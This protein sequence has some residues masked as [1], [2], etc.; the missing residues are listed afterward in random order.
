MKIKTTLAA[1]LI[2]AT[3]ALP[4]APL[5]DTEVDAGV[6]VFDNAATAT[7][8]VADAVDAGTQE[9]TDAVQSSVQD[10]VNQVINS[11]ATATT[12]VVAEVAE[13]ATTVETPVEVELTN[14]E[15]EDTTEVDTT[16]PI[17]A[18]SETEVDA[19]STVVTGD[20]DVNVTTTDNIA[21]PAPEDGSVTS[22]DGSD[23]PVDAGGLEATEIDTGAAVD[24]VSTQEVVEKP[25][26]DVPG[27]SG[28][29]ET[30]V[31]ST[32]TDDRVQPLAQ[33]GIESQS[34]LYA[35]LAALLGAVGFVYFR[36][37]KADGQL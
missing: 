10:V 15:V 17:D 33:T 4:L 5:A 24:V 25:V 14:P 23:L 8:E 27:D 20:L 29:E 11:A 9:V 12:E 36:K 34:L 1:T 31:T 37:T 13:A 3:V 35:A 18:G 32:I 21:E 30:P 28:V 19:G 16:T 6:S 22:G 26:V 7:Q 2:A